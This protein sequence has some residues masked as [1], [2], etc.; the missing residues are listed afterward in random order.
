MINIYF[1]PDTNLPELVSATKEYEKIWQEEGKRIIQ[2]IEKLSLLKFSE[3]Q[4]YAIV[5]EGVSQ[6][7]PLLLRA[8]YPKEVKKATLIHELCHRFLGNNSI[9]A[10]A[11]T[12]VARELEA[13]KQ[14]DLILY[15][16]WCSLYGERFARENV[17]IESSRREVYQ[18]AWHWALSFSLSDR[19]EKF[20]ELV[21]LSKEK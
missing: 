21:Q 10:K 19:Q 15:D 18:Q 3:Q 9:R 13:H 7:H 8:S 11:P 16:T 14:I 4:I 2:T 5:Y 12:L 17:E 20:Q 1:Y 6:S